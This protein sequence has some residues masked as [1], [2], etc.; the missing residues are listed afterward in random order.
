M[1]VNARDSVGGCDP[2]I[3]CKNALFL[4]PMAA[5]MGDELAVKMGIGGCETASLGIGRV[6]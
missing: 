5:E 6:A 3:A 1:L 4:C 2:R